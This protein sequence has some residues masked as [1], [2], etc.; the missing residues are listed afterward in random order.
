MSVAISCD[1]GTTKSLI[2][3]YIKRELRSLGDV[4][5]VDKSNNELH[6]LAISHTSKST[7]NK[8][9]HTSISVIR[10]TRTNSYFD[11]MM[12]LVKYHEQLNIGKPDF[13]KI[14]EIADGHSKKGYYY[15]PRHSLIVN[16][17]D[18]DLHNT[19]KEIVADF[20]TND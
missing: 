16:I 9:G 19:C 1:D 2:E 5:I 10:I 4:S 7:G 12:A 17:S 13:D 20:D 3:S 14:M 6:L 11:I 8:T 15:Y 18:N